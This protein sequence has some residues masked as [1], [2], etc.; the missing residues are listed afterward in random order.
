MADTQVMIF[1]PDAQWYCETLA[2]QCPG[3]SFLPAVTVEDALS[4]AADAEILCG[5]APFIPVEMIKAMPKLKWVQAL[6]TG[7]DHLLH[8]PELT[9]DVV[10]TNTRGMHG[11]QM[12]E[13]AV[14]M[15]LSL[16]R[17]FPAMLANQ[18]ASKWKQW[19]Q[20]LLQ[21][22]TVCIVGLGVIAEAL[23]V[24]CNAFG[25][26]VTGVSDGR[27]EVDG[28]AR[29]FKRSQIKEAA[30]EADFVVVIVP[31]GPETHHIVN[32]GVLKAMKQSAYLINIAR[33]GCVDQEAVVDALNSGEIA[34]AGL[35]V[36]NTEPL[37]ET[38]PLWTV[39]NLIITPHIGGM[40]DCYAQQAQPIVAENLNAYAKGGAAALKNV[41]ERAS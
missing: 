7:V 40:S 5:L 37:P 30:A 16:A 31:Y 23:T 17:Q 19:P 24:R 27:S 39:P 28:F 34:G 15:M 14:L 25:M 6:T 1:D 29:I 12:S 41:I 9:S 21:N 3:Y 20:P 13:L 26:R 8:M 18:E 35:D 10:I 36:F 38:S 2:H 33:G 11:P 4:V 22:K 32:A